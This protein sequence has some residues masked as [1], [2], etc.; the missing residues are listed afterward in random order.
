MR[1][2]TTSSPPMVMANSHPHNRG[3][4]GRATSDG[5]IFADGSAMM[6]P[7]VHLLGML[8]GGLPDG[9]KGFITPDIEK[10]LTYIAAEIPDNGYLTGNAFSGADVQMSYVLEVARMGNL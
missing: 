10:T 8:T 2:L 6:P 5:C 1:L 4:P 7:L 9:L 3:R